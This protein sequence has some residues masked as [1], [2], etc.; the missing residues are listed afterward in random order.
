MSD[1]TNER[2]PIDV[3]DARA[4]SRLEHECAAA[5]TRWDAV[6]AGEVENPRALSRGEF[7]AAHLSSHF[8][9]HAKRS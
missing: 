5:A 4:L 7:I 6:A 9:F 8:D 1:S 3:V 2:L